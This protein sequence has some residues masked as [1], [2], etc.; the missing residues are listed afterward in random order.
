MERPADNPRV[1]PHE[2][3]FTPVD[4]L[5]EEE[6]GEEADLLREALRYHDHRYYVL[7]DPVIADGLYDRL[8]SR[9]QELEEAWPDLRTDDSPTRR[10]GGVVRDELPT[11]EH[12]APMLSLDSGHEEAAVREFDQRVRRGLEA[13][14]EVDYVAELKFD[15]LSI[16]LVYRDGGLERAATRG[17]GVRGEDVTE[18]VRTIGSVP[19]R[20]GGA[21]PPLLAVRGEVYM[22]LA[23]FHAMNRERVERNEEPFANPRNAAAGALRV[24]DSSITAS[25]PLDAVFFDILAVEWDDGPPGSHRSELEALEGWGFK[26]DGRTR[27]MQGIDAAI[28]YHHELEEARDD[29]PYEIDGIVLKV[30][31]R[32]ARERLGVRSR[33]PRFAFAYKFAPRLEVTTVEDIVISVGRTGILTPLA[34]LAPVE[35]G[36]VTIS[37]ASLHNY[38]Q[39]RDKDVRP[40]DRIRVARAGDV[41]PYVVER[42]DERPDDER[43]PPFEMPDSCPVS[44]SDIVRDGAYFVCTGGLS[45]P[46]QLQGS[47]IHYASRPAL[48]IEGVGEKTVLQLMDADLIQDSVVDLYDL[49]FDDLLPLEGF[50]E[51]KAEN[52]V[53][54]VEASKDTTLGRFIYALGI[55]HVGEHVADVLARELGDIHAVMDAEE[56]RLQEIR[57]IGPEVAH[58]IREFFDQEENREVV[59]RLLERGVEPRVEE[60]RDVFDGERFVITGGLDRR[61]RDETDDLLD[62]LGARVTSSV[63][64]RTD[65]VVVGEN[66]GSKADRARE[67]DVEILDEEGLVRLLRDRGVTVD[68]GANMTGVERRSARRRR[69]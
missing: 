46:A 20:L 42:V 13:D 66:P 55:R 16:E 64:G 31:S 10:V 3:D 49:T 18:N 63:S 28:D 2:P 60:R 43:P 19:L 33:S 38:D 47:V 7:D 40:G 65:W 15:G 27:A 61:T 35:V 25:R 67:L 32:E 8:F 62:R 56:E 11:V 5:S 59:E 44:G 6:A 4:E 50:A 54:A 21:P 24:L 51:T 12:L 53:E 26:V 17:D 29:L 30:D 68:R 58:S 41:I 48:D 37:R 52:L 57:E 45:C 36:G 14:G 69:P 9:L 39:V 23:G 22:P 1:E 34:L